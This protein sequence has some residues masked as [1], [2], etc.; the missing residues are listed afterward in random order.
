MSLGVSTRLYIF[1]NGKD[2][3]DCCREPIKGFVGEFKCFDERVSHWSKVEEVG[4][5]ASCLFGT[6]VTGS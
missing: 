5:L 2:S 4:T 1:Y 3:G 6:G